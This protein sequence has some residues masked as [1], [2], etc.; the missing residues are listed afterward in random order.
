MNCY[1]VKIYDGSMG[2]G[3]TA[4][5]CSNVTKAVAKSICRY[6]NRQICQQERICGCP[7][8]IQYY[9]D[10]PDFHEPDLDYWR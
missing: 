1:L 8:D 7:I 3:A 6:F 9:V 4:T 2:C 10:C 5:Y